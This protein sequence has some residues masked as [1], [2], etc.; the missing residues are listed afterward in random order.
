MLEKFYSNFKEFVFRNPVNGFSKFYTENTT[1][2]ENFSE[3]LYLASPEFY[4]SLIK[5]NFNVREM[6]TKQLE[7]IYKYHSRSYFRATPF[8]SFSGVGC[9]NIDDEVSKIHLKNS[10]EFKSYTRLD[11]TYLCQL[12]DSLSNDIEI[13]KL[14]NYKMNNSLYKFCNNYRYTEYKVE[15][16]KRVYFLSEIESDEAINLLVEQV[17]NYNPYLDIVDMIVKA[18]SVT[19]DEAEDYIDSL[20]ESQVLTNNLEPHVTGENLIDVLIETIEKHNIYSEKIEIVKEIRKELREI[21]LLPLSKKI[22]RYLRVEQ[23]LESLEIGYDRQLLFQSDLLITTTQASLNKYIIKDL[24]EG[25]CFLNKFSKK[26]ENHALAKFKKDFYRRYENASIPLTLILDADVGIGI[27][28]LTPFSTDLTP[29]LKNRMFDSSQSTDDVSISS[30]DIF[31]IKKFREFQSQNL[32]EIRITDKEISDMKED[33]SGF[34]KTFSVFIELLNRE[35]NSEIPYIHLNYVSSGSAADLIARFTHLDH[36]IENLTNKILQKESE[37]AG[38]NKI[39]AEIAHLPQSRN[40]NI[41]FRQ[42]T[43]TYEIP[44]LAKSLKDD[45]FQIPL[46]DILVSVPNGEKIVLWSKK[47]NKEIVPMNTNAYNFSLNP[48]LTHYFLCL[49][50]LQQREG[51]IFNWGKVL[52]SEPYLPR[53]VYKKIIISPARWNI[54]TSEVK[55]FAEIIDSKSFYEEALKFKIA[56]KLPSRLFLINGDNKLFIDFD[57]E[58]S[59]KVLFRTLLKSNSIL[60]EFLEYEY[61]VISN[62]DEFFRNEIIINYF[63][64]DK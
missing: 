23:K 58:T 30:S 32:S 62:K 42:S 50:H 53:V 31:L 47:H 21:D 3:S 63:Q 64:N 18:F 9:G 52:E 33:W 35:N 39:L 38:S 10:S 4:D 37:L 43:R 5:I 14:L 61:P 1:T 25:I 26:N 59:L 12:I 17:K 13:R 55:Y 54:S 45:E 36:K 51:L 48:V 28:N 24:N 60:Q 20:I 2:N 46:T 11:M 34:P 7:S 27:S 41:L 15:S 8:G 40:G 16:K 6:N 22:S 44:F 56:K 29:L 57:N 19:M 49:L